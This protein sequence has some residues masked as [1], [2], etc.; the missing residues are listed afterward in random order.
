[1]VWFFSRKFIFMAHTF[2][3]MAHWFCKWHIDVLG[4]HGHGAIVTFT[5][6]LI[7]ITDSKKKNKIRKF[8]DIP[9]RPTLFFRWPWPEPHIFSYLAFNEN[10]FLNKGQDQKIEVGKKTK[11]RLL[12]KN[13]KIVFYGWKEATGVLTRTSCIT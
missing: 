1:M 13:K 8:I 9:F 4:H 12:K 10:N 2:Q 5:S 6:I 7:P 3:R 11:F